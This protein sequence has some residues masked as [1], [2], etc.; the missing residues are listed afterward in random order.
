MSGFVLPDTPNLPD[1]LT[2]LANSVQIPTTALPANSQWPGYA[3]NQ[4]M[5]LAIPPSGLTPGVMYS[6]AVYNGATHVLFAITPDQPGQ[7]YFASARSTGAG[8]YG[9]IAPS[10][11][12]VAASADQGTSQTLEI[13]EWAKNL[14]ADQ[15]DYYKTPWGRAFLAWN[16][17]YGPTIWGLT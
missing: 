4:A 6:L 2:F 12:L 1:F 17:K 9:L 11:G 8:G 16:Q 7:S 13:P 14:T 10:T 15:L 3:F 5:A